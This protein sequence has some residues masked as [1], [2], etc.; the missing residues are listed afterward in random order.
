[1]KKDISDLCPCHSGKKYENCCQPYHQGHPAPNAEK[2][3]RSRYSAY[4]LGITDYIIATSL[5]VMRSDKKS[6]ERFCTMTQ[7]DDLKI[8]S[9]EECENEAFVT[10][11]AFLTQGGQDATFTEKSRF[12]KEKGKWYYAGAEILQG[13]KK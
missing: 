5:E 1:M 12:A 3:M 6:I 4:A 8:Q 13:E 2:L 7:F 11:T 10:F 9:F